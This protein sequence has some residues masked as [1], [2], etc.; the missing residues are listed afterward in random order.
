MKIRSPNL[1]PETIVENICWVCSRRCG[2][3]GLGGSTWGTA[4]GTLCLRLRGSQVM[5]AP[6]RKCLAAGHSGRLI[7]PGSCAGKH[8][9]ISHTSQGWGFALPSLVSLSEGKATT[10]KLWCGKLLR[11]EVRK[12]TQDHQRPKDWTVCETRRAS[13]LWT[14]AH[15]S[16][17]GKSIRENSVRCLKSSPRLFTPTAVTELRNASKGQKHKINTIQ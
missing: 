6:P 12:A 4:G 10:L 7:L 8:W 2:A 15:Q 11:T 1:K 9:A 16:E 17:A 14:C 5:K 13:P 3:S